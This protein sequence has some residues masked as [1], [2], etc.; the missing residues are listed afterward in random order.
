MGYP[1]A[2][3]QELPVTTD[4]VVMSYGLPGDRNLVC[5]M[6]IQPLTAC[7]HGIIPNWSQ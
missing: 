4:V 6:R 3:E 5:A 1:E 7:R 2:L